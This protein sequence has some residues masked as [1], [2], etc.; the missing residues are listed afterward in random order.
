MR[1]LVVLALA[2]L[3][4]LTAA[5]QV[6][7]PE[8]CID[9]ARFSTA[10]VHFES[11][12]IRGALSPSEIDCLETAYHNATVQTDK[13]K[14]SRVLLANAYVTNTEQW[15]VLVRRHLDEVEQSDPDISYL[16]A[17]Y[18]FNREKPDYAGVYRY[19]ELSWERR[20]DRW[21]G[22]TYTTRVHHLLRL[23]AIASLR[24]WELA[25]KAAVGKGDQGRAAADSLRLRTSTVAREWLDFDRA[26]QLPWLEAAEVCISASS[27]QGCG[28]KEDWRATAF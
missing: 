17:M 26:G 21:E 22:Q 15:A 7:P 13:A 23:R 16:F 25:E 18:L 11:R 8:E 5:A 28:L 6:V 12:A 27:E 3:V 9:F 10:L 4:P 24:M 1:T 20:A 14:I 19:A 2:L